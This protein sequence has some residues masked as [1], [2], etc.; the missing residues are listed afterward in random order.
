MVAVY[1]GHDPDVVSIPG[2]FCSSI[3]NVVGG[4]SVYMNRIVVVRLPDGPHQTL[5]LFG[6]FMNHEKVSD[7]TLGSVKLDV[8]FLGNLQKRGSQSTNSTRFG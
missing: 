8:H 2:D 6:F 1:A 5:E 4:C 7:T 3:E